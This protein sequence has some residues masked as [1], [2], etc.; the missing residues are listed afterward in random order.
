MQLILSLFSGVGLLD[1]AFREKGFCV[2][3]AGD[4]ITGQDIRDF[5]TIAGRFDGVIAG[6]PCQDFSTLKRE[7]GDYS[8]EMVNE[9]VRIVKQAQPKW[10]L[11]ENV[12][13]VPDV[14]VYDYSWQ[15]IDINQGWY[16]DTSRLR[17]IQFGSKEELYLDIPRGNM[18]G[19]K[20]SCALASD[21]RSF[22]ELCY[23]QGLGDDYDLPDFNVAGKKKAVGNGV[24]LA[25]GRVLAD[26]VL[27]VTG[28]GTLPV[29]QK[30]KNNVNDRANKSVTEQPRCPCGCMRVLTGRKKYYDASC[31]K[32][33]Q[34][35]REAS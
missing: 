13:G 18:D 4:L 27:K 16:S 33:G 14:T 11:L 7:R 30:P 5:H 1:Q 17:H 2:V 34:R 32:R 21:D 24:P 9:F 29:T 26:A 31:R 12:R 19:V 3:S 23:L 20:Y 22:K 35:R 6:T 25:I 8:M 28:P 10:W 15:R